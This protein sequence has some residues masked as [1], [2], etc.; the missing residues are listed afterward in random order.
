MFSG[1]PFLKKICKI[2]WLGQPMSNPL[3]ESVV[4]IDTNIMTTN[5]Q[6][7]LG[8]SAIQPRVFGRRREQRVARA[9]WWFDRMRTAVQSAWQEQSQ[10]RPEQI[11]LAGVNREIHA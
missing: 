9:K 7:E 2:F 5:E 8:F 11:F 4:V 1:F 10:Q 3:C 6:L